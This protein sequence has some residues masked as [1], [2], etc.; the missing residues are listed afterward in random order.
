M[1]SFAHESALHVREGDHDSVDLP[2][3]DH[4]LQL[5]EAWVL[6]VVAVVA[7]RAPRVLRDGSG[8]WGGPVGRSGPALR[9][10]GMAMGRWS[11]DLSGGLFELALDLGEFGGV[12]HSPR[13]LEARRAQ[14]K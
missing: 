4:R 1:D 5:G 2:V 14:P 8:G 10:C 13:A 6:V 9:V 12:T 11:R 3:A 7:H